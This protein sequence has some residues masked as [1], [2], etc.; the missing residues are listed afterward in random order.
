MPVTHPL[1]VATRAALRILFVFG[2]FYDDDPLRNT[3]LIGGQ[4]DPRLGVHR[5]QHVTGLDAHWFSLDVLALD[6]DLGRSPYITN[7]PRDG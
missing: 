6:H 7:Q 2:Q 3:D 4:S 1:N 5:L